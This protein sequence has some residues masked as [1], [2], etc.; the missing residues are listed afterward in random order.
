MRQ[1]LELL[2][3]RKGQK[4]KMGG[5]IV[6]FCKRYPKTGLLLFMA[7]LFVA[8]SFAGGVIVSFVGM[9]GQPARDWGLGAGSFSA[10]AGGIW[11]MLYLVRRQG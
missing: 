11:Y 5:K 7:I 4:H 9:E 10:I 8:V 3:S 6:D 2:Q 1:I